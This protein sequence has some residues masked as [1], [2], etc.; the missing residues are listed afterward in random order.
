M[1]EFGKMKVFSI[2]LVTIFC[3]SNLPAQNDLQKLVETEK[4]FDRTAAEKGEKS[5]F[6]DFAAADGVVFQPG[7]VNARTY[8]SER[9]ETDDLL[10]RQLAFADVSANGVLGYTVGTSSVKPKNDEKNQTAFGDYVTIW[11]KQPDGMYKF[12][13]DIGITHAPPSNAA[14]DW[15]FF[16]ERQT[17]AGKIPPVSAASNMFYDEA[18]D[19]GLESAYQI[20]AAEDARFYRQGKPPITGKTAAL[21]AFKKEKL[22]VSFNKKMILQSAGDLAFSNVAYELNK[23]GKT[24]EKGNSVQIWKFLD[25]RWQIVADVFSP[26]PKEKN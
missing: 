21:A 24:V 5:A 13:L 9:G 11:Q 14:P 2:V 6:L 23:N 17:A 12:A 18:T 22:K 3:F 10:V 16:G 19:H 7:A 8:W 25:D 1:L 20:F 26:L 4:S 15:K